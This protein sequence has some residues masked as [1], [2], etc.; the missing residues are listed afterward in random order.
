MSLSPMIWK[1]MGVVRPWHIWNHPIETTVYTLDIPSHPPVIHGEGV[2][3]SLDPLKAEP[4][5]MFGGS[6]MHRSSRLV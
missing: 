4:H 3:V 1:I 2:G 6:N 5:G